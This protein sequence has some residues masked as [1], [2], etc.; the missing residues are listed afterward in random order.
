MSR[1]GDKKGT[2]WPEVIPYRISDRLYCAPTPS[3]PIPRHSTPYRLRIAI[4]PLA[5]CELLDHHH[6]EAIK[7][8]YNPHKDYLSRRDLSVFT[9]AYTLCKL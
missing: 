1:D 5:L 9:V 2:D 6:T 7:N 3:V 4:T 8:F